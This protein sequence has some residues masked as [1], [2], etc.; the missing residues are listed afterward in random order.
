MLDHDTTM[1]IEAYVSLVASRAMKRDIRQ[2]RSALV[3][4]MSLDRMGCPK[5]AKAQYEKA[6]ELLKGIGED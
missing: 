5:E 4:G 6:I 2:A 1:D 3:L